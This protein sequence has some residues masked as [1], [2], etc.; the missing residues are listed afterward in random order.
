MKR[1]LAIVFFFMAV[2]LSA[3]TGIDAGAGSKSKE[4]KSAPVITIAKDMKTFR[5]IELGME[6][7][8]VKKLLL[9]DPLFNYRGEPDVMFTPDRKETIIECSGNSYVKR[10]Y[11]QF[12]EN[13]LFIITIVLNSVTL[14][15]FTMFETLSKKYGEPSS[16]NPDEAVW[17]FSDARLSLEKPLSVKYIA[18]KTFEK[19]LESGNAEAKAE[20]MARDKFLGEF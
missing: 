2:S 3:Q 19:L 7:P 18:T 16:L 9:A 4:T 20:D 8:A 5:S 10:A 17:L 12:N 6:L 15:Y 14:D 11:F 13:K 1:K